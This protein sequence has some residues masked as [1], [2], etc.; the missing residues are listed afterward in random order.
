MPLIGGP[1]AKGA[2]P[3]FAGF[4]GPA[5][6]K[7]ILVGIGSFGGLDWRG[8]PR[9]APW[10]GGLVQGPNPADRASGHCVCA[11]PVSSLPQKFSNKILAE[12]GFG[13]QLDS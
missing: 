8:I 9:T 10:A 2:R 1:H 13:N 5:R 7:Q 4:S 11:A 12:T 6:S 3:H